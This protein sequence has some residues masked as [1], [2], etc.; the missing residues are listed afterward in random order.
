MTV[1]GSVSSGCFRVDPRMF[2]VFL[3]RGPFGTDFDTDFGLF[4]G[5]FGWSWAGLERS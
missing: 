1:F 2:P 5:A 4:S 3:F